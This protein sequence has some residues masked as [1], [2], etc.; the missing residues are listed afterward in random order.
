[1]LQSVSVTAAGD[2]GG[3]VVTVNVV[4]GVVPHAPAPAPEAFT[5]T[6]MLDDPSD[7]VTTPPAKAVEGL[8][9]RIDRMLVPLT[10]AVTL[11]LPD[12]AV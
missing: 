9:R 11:L 1:M 4:G 10:V 2:V 7:T 6:V 3:V 5:V 12:T 8:V